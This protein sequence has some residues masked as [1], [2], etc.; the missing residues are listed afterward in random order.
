MKLV[1]PLTF[2]ILG[3]TMGGLAASR[4]LHA[5]PQN[6]AAMA[7]LKVAP[8]SFAP[9]VEM[10]QP[11][12]VNVFTT[13]TVSMGRSPFRIPGFPD[14]FFGPQGEVPEEFEREGMGS[15]FIISPDG[16][17]LT[18][19]HVV[20]D[21]DELRV[22]LTDGEELVAEVVGT[23]P[24][25]DVA[26]IKVEADE[27]LPS[28]EMGSSSELRVGD[29]V[30]AIGNPLGLSH[31]VTA[32]IVSAKSRIIGA[33]TYDDFI[34]TD[35]SI[36]QG[37]SGGPLLD[38][39]GQVVGINTAISSMG[40]GIAFAV[41][42]DMVKN[43][44]VDLKANGRVARGWLG[45]KMQRMD[46]DLA[47]ALGLD[48]S[49]GALVAK[50]YQG[51][52]A[53]Q[54]GLQAGD[55]VLS[56]NSEEIED[57]DHLLR[58]VGRLRPGNSAA[59]TVLRDGRKKKIKAT[60][61]ERPGEEQLAE[62]GFRI[63]PEEDQPRESGSASSLERLGVKLQPG[64]SVWGAPSSAKGRMMVVEVARDTPAHGKLER[65]DVLLQIDRQEVHDERDVLQALDKASG[66]LLLLVERR[67]GRMYL[68]VDLGE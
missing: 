33:T 5:G 61:G 1:R 41:P 12:V 68:G 60:L 21:A 47:A 50:V 67:G 34:Q 30:V 3:L 15:G 35:A 51:T 20:E 17:I 14:F 23:D 22:K 7:P 53:E 19:N 28:L 24:S 27:A 8:L 2:L 38:T 39:S 16:Y 32:G 6:P 48:K 45:I 54:A 18:N 31:T 46:A 11:A 26:L 29:W 43:L 58:A 9:L 4:S 36:N 63:A 42:I 25:T 65:G 10:T 64:A 52:P 40:Q 13:Q 59:M 49:K 55:L 44:L 56:F 57:S 66:K 62:G 37:N